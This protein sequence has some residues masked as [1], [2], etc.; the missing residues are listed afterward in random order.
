MA[1][2]AVFFDV[3]E[4][5][6]DE[7]GYWG[8]VARLVGVPRHVVLAALGATIARGES[9]HCVYELLGVDRPA[10]VDDVVYGRNELYPD[11]RPCL[12]H[13]KRDGYLVGI[14]G[15]QTAA[16]E[17]WARNEALPVDVIGSSEGWGVAKPDRAFYARV[18]AEADC[19]A[20]DIAYVGD[21]VDND[22]LPALEAGLVAVHVRRGP[23]GY[24]QPGAE[25]A[26]IRLDSLA[27][28]P[29]ALANV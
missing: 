17:R 3:G 19:D 1:V 18:V 10:A 5:L 6:V 8:R 2:R 16:L 20:G 9:H 11:A 26:D 15:N 13:L 28:L 25:R 22:V 14:A 27:G 23:W 29:Q 4:T 7:S 21:R 12:A 24:L